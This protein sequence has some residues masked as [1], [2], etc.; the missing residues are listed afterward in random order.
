[1]SPRWDLHRSGLLTIPRGMVKWKYRHPR[2][3]YKVSISE[4]GKDG[5]ILS[6]NTSESVFV[7]S[8]AR[9]E[10]P[11][12]KAH[13]I[14]RHHGSS[15]WL[16]NTACLAGLLLHAC[17]DLLQGVCLSK[18]CGAPTDTHTPALQLPLH[19][20]RASDG[21]YWWELLATKPFLHLPVLLSSSKPR[22]FIHEHKYSLLCLSH[23]S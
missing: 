11:A 14:S 13:T 10:I 23:G 16:Q 17:A 15:L 12:T 2:S 5:W 6:E 9:V 8:A 3:S 20:A 7:C 1:M 4:G 18:R 22:P 19:P 21:L